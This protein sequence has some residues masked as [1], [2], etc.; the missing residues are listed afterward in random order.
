M[1]LRPSPKFL[2]D[3]GLANACDTRSC[4]TF[5]FFPRPNSFIS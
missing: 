2:F 1:E 4:G 3:R 5:S